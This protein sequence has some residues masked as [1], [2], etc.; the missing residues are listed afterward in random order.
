MNGAEIQD[1]ADKV[2]SKL[3][4]V[5]KSQPFGREYDVFKVAGKVFMMTTEVAGAKIMTA[6]CDPERSKMLRDV[7]PSI[8]PG[9]H[10][11][12]RHWIS[13]AEEKDIDQD[14]IKDLVKTAY[15]LVVQKLPRAKR[16]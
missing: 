15:E 3:S 1:A 14:L 8:T 2:A 5:T 4:G 10:M 7:F 13:V 9:Y 6:K 12:K 16:P 11:N